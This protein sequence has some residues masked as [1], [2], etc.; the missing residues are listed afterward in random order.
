MKGVSSVRT[1]YVLSDHQKDQHKERRDREVQ[2]LRKTEG[3][4][5]KAPG[6]EVDFRQKEGKG[7]EI[8]L[9]RRR[10]EQMSTL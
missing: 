5:S 7:K 3:V 1:K 10:R 9:N 2:F 4:R 6:E 8:G